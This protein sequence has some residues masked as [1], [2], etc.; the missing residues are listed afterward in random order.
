MSEKEIVYI[1]KSNLAKHLG[2]SGQVVQNLISRKLI[3]V[4]TDPETNQVLVEKIDQRPTRQYTVN[5]IYNLRS[6]RTIRQ[7]NENND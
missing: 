2:V 4:K 7:K 3:A 1:T 5:A 6:D